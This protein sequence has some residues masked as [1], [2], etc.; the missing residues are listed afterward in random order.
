MSSGQIAP[1][2]SAVDVVGQPVP[3][4]EPLDLGAA[5]ELVQPGLVAEDRAAVALGQ[6]LGVAQVV[7]VAEDDAPHVAAVEPLD[8]LVGKERID[9][10]A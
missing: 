8:S 3:E 6:L 10:G 7:A 5:L 2:S 4:G 1:I 9:R